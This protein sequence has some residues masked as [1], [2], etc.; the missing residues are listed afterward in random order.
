MR[1]PE[2]FL[3]EFDAEAGRA[4]QLFSGVF[5]GG[6]HPS[7]ESWQGKTPRSGSDSGKAH[8]GGGS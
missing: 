4:G 6:A 5:K 1:T 8:D 7:L 2:A 3:W